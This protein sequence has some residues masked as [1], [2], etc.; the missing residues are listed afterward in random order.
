LEFGGNPIEAC[1]NVGA[2]GEAGLSES[3]NPDI[4]GGILLAVASAK[5]VWN[6]V[7]KFLSSNKWVIIL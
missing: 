4:W 1:E 2:S 3:W 6:V 7:N 5:C